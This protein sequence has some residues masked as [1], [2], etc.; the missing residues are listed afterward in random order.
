[1][2]AHIDAHSPPQSGWRTS[3]GGGESMTRQ[4]DRRRFAVQFGVLAAALASGA[5]ARA[6]RRLA[7]PDI[8]QS[9]LPGNVRDV[10]SVFERII[11]LEGEAERRRLPQSSLPL[12]QL[13]ALPLDPERLYELALPRL[14]TLIDRSERISPAFADR[15]GALLSELHGGQ[16]ELPEALVPR[17]AARTGK[18]STNRAAAGLSL[19]AQP[20]A[21]PDVEPPPE[22]VEPAAL[23][24]IER[25]DNAAQPEA[26][27]EAP[28]TE[29]LRTHRF[30]DLRDEYLRLFAAA[31]LRP[32][33]NASAQWHADLLRQSQ[34]RYA[35]VGSRV[36]VPWYFI[37]VIH[38]L[39]ASFNFRAHLHNGDFPL[40]ART[41]QVPAGRP[42]VWRPPS[43][44]E[45]SAVDAMRIL[46]FAGQSDWS[47]A[48][49]LHRFEAYNGFGY[50]RRGVASPYLWS[51]S[52]QYDRGKFVADGRWNATARSQQCGAAVM[53]K[54][55]VER[56]E[57]D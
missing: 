41:R 13:L 17:V 46:G 16:R 55:L 45:S 9:V 36:G 49:T 28:P 47:L 53:L 2:L 57:I 5:S 31:T 26:T 12:T 24:T 25:P 3:E 7:I 23:P 39:E 51:F 19:S 1:M 15:A 42:M 22:G 50:R 21:A 44:W 18:A 10:A 30:E 32:Q 33:H 48:R 27:E 35:A 43:D 11:A 6:Q 8:I 29:L 37:G 38:G 52:D 14:V 40:T 56:G 4:I 34:A 20:V 54:L